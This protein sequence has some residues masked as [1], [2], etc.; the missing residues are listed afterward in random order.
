MSYSLGNVTSDRYIKK[1]ECTIWAIRYRKYFSPLTVT[2]P[3]I[4]CKL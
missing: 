1:N 3:S 2:V 4:L